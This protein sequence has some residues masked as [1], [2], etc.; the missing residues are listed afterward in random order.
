VFDW[1]YVG[2]TENPV[3]FGVKLDCSRE[4]TK[5]AAATQLMYRLTQAGRVWNVR[6]ARLCSVCC[7]FA[8]GNRD[9]IIVVITSCRCA[10]RGCLQRTEGDR[11]AIPRIAGRHWQAPLATRQPGQGGTL[12]DAVGRVISTIA[13][14]RAMAFSSAHDR[15]DGRPGYL[16]WC[17]CGPYAANTRTGHYPSGEFSLVCFRIADG[18]AASG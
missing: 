17:H 3:S 2:S 6:A 18:F 11:F 15:C 1:I 13:F 4:E 8:S 16:P 12:R 7:D 10:V 9:V 14:R 5:M